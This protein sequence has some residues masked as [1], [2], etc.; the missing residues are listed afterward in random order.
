MTSIDRHERPSLRT[1]RTGRPTKQQARAITRRILDAACEQFLDKG[2]ERASIECI[3]AASGVSKNTVYKRYGD[4][5]ELLCAVVAEALRH[6]GAQIGAAI[7][8][9]RPPDET[10]RR[11]GMA[12]LEAQL[13]RCGD[14][15]LGL[16]LG[17]LIISTSREVPQVAETTYRIFIEETLR[18]VREYFERLAADSVLRVHPNYAASRFAYEIFAL[19]R[20]L[21]YNSP[22]PDDDER[23]TIVSQAV[24]MLLNGVLSSTPVPPPIGRAAAPWPIQREGGRTRAS[25][26]PTRER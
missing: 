16:E 26:K 23:E 2:F 21:V 17:R 11:V 19:D 7:V 20:F 6:A 18:P 10:L 13:G 14:P 25:A 5:G 9:G 24:D 12:I 22:L 3:A 1:A 15:P 8:P 4:K